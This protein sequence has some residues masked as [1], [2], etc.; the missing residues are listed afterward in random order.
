MSVF[1]HFEFDAHERVVFHTDADSGLRAIIAI[2]STRLGASLGGCRMRPYRDSAQAL[3]DVLRLSRAMSYK[4]ALAGLPQGGGKSVI[5]GDPALDKTPALLHAMGRFVDSLNGR[6]IVAED[7]GTCVDDMRLMAQDTAHVSGLTG[8]QAAAA[9]R[10]GDPSPATAAGVLIGMQAAVGRALGCGN[11]AGLRVAIQGVGS[12]GGRLAALLA[13]KGAKLWVTDTHPEALQR[14]VEATGASAVDA[15]AIHRQEVDVFAPCALGGT[16]NADTIPEIRAAAVAG[17]ANNQLATEGDGVSL[18]QR[19]I[20]Y[21]PDYVINAGGIIDI[22]YQGPQYDA[23]VVQAH[24]RRIGTT[25][26]HIFNESEKQ[27][28]S[29]AVIADAMARERLQGRVR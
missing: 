20:V 21:A 15:D 25:L 3:T 11:L 9:G 23:A 17:C 18:Y 24:L 12:V 29:T 14:C 27:D 10:D 1:E 4:A 7:S 2:H 6:Y 22:H 28:C 8:A 5:I 16:L 26:E 13:E 19:G